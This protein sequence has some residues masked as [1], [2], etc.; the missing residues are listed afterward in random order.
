MVQLFIIIQ[1]LHDKLHVCFYNI[2]WSHTSTQYKCASNALGFK[3]I[4][5]MIKLTAHAYNRITTTTETT[6]C[7]IRYNKKAP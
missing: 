5:K 2:Q 4:K 7:E 3:H 1:R 6:E